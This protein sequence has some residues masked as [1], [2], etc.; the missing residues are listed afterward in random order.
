MNGKITLH[1]F[2]IDNPFKPKLISICRPGNFIGSA[3]ADNGI[4]CRPNVF[5]VVSSTTATLI[6]MSTNTF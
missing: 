6:K 2:K 4:S 1:D 3:N 5:S